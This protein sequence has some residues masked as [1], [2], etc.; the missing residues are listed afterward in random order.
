MVFA[1]WREP[2]ANPWAMV[3]LQAA[4]QHVP[5][6]PQLGA[7]DPGPFSFASEAR[8]HR[9]LGEAGFTSIG[10]ESVDVALDLAI[11]GGLEAAMRTATHIGPASR[12]MEGQPEGKRA[13][14][15]EAIRAAL[16]PKVVGN[17]VELGGGVW[18]VTA[19]R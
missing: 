2:R 13:A 9:L 14:A 6:L 4:Y 1:A 15:I 18:I 3:P 19:R 12:A 8:V 10:L 11:G 16:A 17:K 5:K 7:E